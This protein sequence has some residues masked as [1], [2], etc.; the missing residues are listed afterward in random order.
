MIRTSQWFT[1]SNVPNISLTI[2]KQREGEKHV[3]EVRDEVGAED[4][5]EAPLVDGETNS[6]HPEC[7]ASNRHHDL[8]ILVR[9]E[10][11]GVG[12]EVC[13]VLQMSTFSF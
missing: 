12:V 6:G 4:L 1:L 7:N 8:T 9:T 2:S 10:D 3:P 11:D 13:G 5:E